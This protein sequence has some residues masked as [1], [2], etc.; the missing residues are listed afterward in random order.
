MATLQVEG[1]LLRI[2]SSDDGLT[3]FVRMAL[4]L[5]ETRRESVPGELV[6]GRRTVGTFSVFSSVTPTAEAFGNF[7]FPPI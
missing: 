6:N 1:S 7:Q 4:G 3:C 5:G 2:K